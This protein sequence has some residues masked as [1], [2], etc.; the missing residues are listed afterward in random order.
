MILNSDFARG[1]RLLGSL[2]DE[3]GMEKLLD[4]TK[5]SF[6]QKNPNHLTLQDIET[7]DTLFDDSSSKADMS[8]YISLKES[9]FKTFEELLPNAIMWTLPQRKVA[10]SRLLQYL[11]VRNA[12]GKQILEWMSGHNLIIQLNGN[13]GWKVKIGSYEDLDSDVINVLLN[14]GYTEKEIREKIE[15]RKKLFDT[16]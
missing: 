10:N 11:H 2:I 12:M 4:E 3:S 8:T 9:R 15:E 5:A 13:H 6:V 16:D 1:K 7:L 14:A